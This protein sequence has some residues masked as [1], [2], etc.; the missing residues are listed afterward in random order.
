M[1]T[2]VN[3]IIKNTI[4][5]RNTNASSLSQPFARST[6]NNSTSTSPAVDSGLSA[7]NSGENSGPVRAVQPVLVVTFELLL[8]LR[9]NGHRNSCRS[10]DA[11][12][13]C[14]FY[15]GHHSLSHDKVS[16]LS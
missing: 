4:A 12:P 13:Y 10:V 2:I 15:S 8:L 11:G 9:D 1:N 14:V 16:S 3:T 6:S 5:L 7:L